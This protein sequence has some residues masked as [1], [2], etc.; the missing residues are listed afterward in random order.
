MQKRAP[1]NHVEGVAHFKMWIE[2]VSRTAIAP[3]ARNSPTSAPGFND[4]ALGGFLLYR[5]NSQNSARGL[6]GREIDV[7]VRSEERRVGKECRL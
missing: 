1:S 5:F 6:V 4:L 2:P 7:A 3:P